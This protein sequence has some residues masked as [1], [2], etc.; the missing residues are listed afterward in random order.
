MSD[1]SRFDVT[2]VGGGPAGL[3]AALVLGRCCRKVLVVD[4]GNPRNI[5]S[6]GVHGF[7]SREG[8]APAELLALTRTQL[9]PYAVTFR[10]GTIMT[11]DRV[12]DGFRIGLLDGST[13]QSR[14]VLLATGVVDKLPAW[15]GIEEFYGTSVHH[16]PYCDGWEHRDGRIAVHGR[17]KG[18][19]ALSV[20]MKTWSRDV[21]FCSDGPARLHASERQDLQRNGIDV[22]EKKIRRL[23]GTLGKLERVVFEDG[24]AI[25][26]TGLFFSTGNM[27][28]STLPQEI[29]CTLTPKGAV[30]AGR[31]QRSSCPGIFVAGD[32]AED[33]HYVIVA[34]A[35]GAKAAMH[36]NAELSAED[37][38]RA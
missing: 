3:S 9:T 4:A 22:Y 13:A 20:L 17:G 2:V 6:R 34:A 28:R 26:R 36:I 30:R 16:C 35:E 5:R 15:E 21:V 31:D 32:A 18:G 27:Q 14:K 25:P 24:T 33:S 19:A 7:I 11:V 12:E 1:P 29:G 8:C 10:E 38:A 23:E 37:R